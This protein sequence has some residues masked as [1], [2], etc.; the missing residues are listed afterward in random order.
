MPEE[1]YMKGGLEKLLPDGMGL[2]AVSKR[3]IVRKK[4]KPENKKGAR[5]LTDKEKIL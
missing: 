4:V 5:K 1:L 2:W 3:G